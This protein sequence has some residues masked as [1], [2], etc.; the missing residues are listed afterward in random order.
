MGVCVGGGLRT[1]DHLE[2]LLK[3]SCWPQSAPLGLRGGAGPLGSS[4]MVLP[5]LAQAHPQWT[6]FSLRW[7]RRP[8]APTLPDQTWTL[9]P[10]PVPAPQ[11]LPAS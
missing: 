2:A 1:S 7:P 5:S 8:G 10:R 3:G 4:H 9:P 6:I 11:V